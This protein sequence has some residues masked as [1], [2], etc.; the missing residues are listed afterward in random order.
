MKKKF[1]LGRFFL[2]IVCFSVC[3]SGITIRPILKERKEVYQ[4]I[5]RQ[6][7]GIKGQLKSVFKKSGKWRYNM[8]IDSIQ[9]KEG[10]WRKL[11]FLLKGQIILPKKIPVNPGQILYI[12]GKAFVPK[13]YQKNKSE[14]EKN[15]KIGYGLHYNALYIKEVSHWESKRTRIKNIES[16]LDQLR[17]IVIKRINSEK[18]SIK[19]REKGFL[20]AILTGE[21]WGLSPWLKKIFK[22]GGIYHILAVSGTHMGVWILSIIMICYAVGCP[23]G[24]TWGLLIFILGS[25]LIFLG[26]TGS[27][28]RS[29]GM[30]MG[31]YLS[32]LLGKKVS[33]RTILWIS[34]LTVLVFVPSYSMDLS[35]SLS[36]IALYSIVQSLYWSYQ[37]GE[38]VFPSHSHLGSQKITIIKTI[39]T[40]CIVNIGVVGGTG[41]LL[42]YMTKEWVWIGCISN[43]ILSPLI[44]VIIILS[45]LS[46]LSAMSIKVW[47]IWEWSLGQNML[48]ELFNQLIWLTYQLSKVPPIKMNLNYKEMICT[49]IIIMGGLVL[50]NQGLKEIKR[51]ILEEKLRVNNAVKR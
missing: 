15:L 40:Y 12:K 16:Y 25:A 39:M 49:Y 8:V 51:R 45:M 2:G 18:I 35:F 33:L 28:V 44:L 29:Y 9:K 23:L 22:A 47:S 5:N 6:Q 11:K 26:G 19:P 14:W 37:L 13:K 20:I 21:R 34:T 4:T 42:V 10:D 27:I 24:V 46:G 3:L 31:L 43:L 7:V 1:Y 41:P 32:F 50:V 17:S 38:M 30:F 48:N 36:F